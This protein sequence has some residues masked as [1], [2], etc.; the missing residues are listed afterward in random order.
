METPSDGH[1][2]VVLADQGVVGIE[3]ISRGG[4]VGFRGGFSSDLIEDLPN[5]PDRWGV[6]VPRCTPNFILN[7][8]DFLILYVGGELGVRIIIGTRR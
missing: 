8:I 6:V 2:A 4:D 1:V 5:S 3:V 7:F